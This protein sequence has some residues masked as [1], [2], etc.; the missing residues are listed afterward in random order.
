M[1]TWCPNGH[2]TMGIQTQPGYPLV[3][4]NVAIE[5][6]HRNSGFSHEKWWIFQFAMLNYQRVSI[7]ELITI[8][9]YEKCTRV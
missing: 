5:N 9:F 6:G 1:V 3:M 7:N 8:L 2:P 4:F